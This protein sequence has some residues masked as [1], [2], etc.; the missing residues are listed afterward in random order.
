M[1][2][3]FEYANKV[4]GGSA[5]FADGK[6]WKFHIYA[7]TPAKSYRHIPT[8]NIFFQ[9]FKNRENSLLQ[10]GLKWQLFILLNATMLTT[11]DITPANHE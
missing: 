11:V 10:L 5:H 7:Y 9:F 2:A 4:E 6:F 8:S 3:I 1:A